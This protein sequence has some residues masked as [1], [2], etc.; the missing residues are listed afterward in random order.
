MT[1]ISRH[2]YL[3][4]EITDESVIGIIKH[5][6]LIND[7]DD[8]EEESIIGMAQS[9]I[10]QGIIEPSDIKIPEREPIMLEINCGG[11]SLSAGFML[12]TAIENSITPIIGYA[13]GYC[14]SMAVAV[15]AS[16]NFKMSNR[17]ASFMIHDVAG[18][19]FGK[20]GELK[21]YLGHADRGRE[22]YKE[23]IVTG[24]RISSETLEGLMSRNHDY[25]FSPDEA[26]EYGIVD[27]IDING[28]DLDL[29]AEK[30]Y[31]ILPEEIAEVEE[32]DND[33]IDSM[34]VY[35]DDKPL[36]FSNFDV[37]E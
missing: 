4:E 1:E 5:I 7:I 29:F 34:V 16:C 15:L 23:V 33:D 30:V 26:L 17:F 10:T 8:D 27:G 6:N 9:L 13:T 3:N 14:M 20:F 36:G 24:T 31:G 11:G 2:L 35:S 19:F 21:P 22:N 25:F 12:I 32:I 28:I 37:K 18:G